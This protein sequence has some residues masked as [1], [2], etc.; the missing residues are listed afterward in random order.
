MKTDGYA[1]DTDYDENREDPLV[2]KLYSAPQPPLNPGMMLRIDSRASGNDSGHLDAREQDDAFNL[3]GDLG[4]WLSIVLVTLVGLAVAYTVNYQRKS[5]KSKIKLL[6]EGSGTPGPALQESGHELE[7]PTSAPPPRES[8]SEGNLQNS[9]VAARD[10]EGVPTSAYM[11][12]ASR[13]QAQNDE[14]EPKSPAFPQEAKTKGHIP[15]G[16][17]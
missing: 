5:G 11:S 15:G 7:S 1:S 16:K 6:G 10:N 12:P 8:F 9:A 14:E 13:S 4:T 2:T 17:Y 3:T